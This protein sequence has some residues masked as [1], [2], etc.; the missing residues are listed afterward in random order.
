V[1]ILEATEITLFAIFWLVQTR[2]HWGET[3]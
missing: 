3:V 1:L 2:E